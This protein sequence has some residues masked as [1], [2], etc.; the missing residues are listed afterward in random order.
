MKVAIGVVV[1]FLLIVGGYTAILGNSISGEDDGDKSLAA[2][3]VEERAERGSPSGA[4]TKAGEE[5]H[6]TNPGLTREQ[7][8]A[9]AQAKKYLAASAYSRGGLVQQL[10]LD[11]YSTQDSIY[12]VDYMKVNWNKQAAAKAREHLD[13]SAHSRAELIEQLKFDGFSDAQAKFGVKK[14]DF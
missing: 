10:E 5:T 12:A 14:A 4:G 7:S 13:A 3:K 1:A 2:R 8:N 6:D 11:G 9:T